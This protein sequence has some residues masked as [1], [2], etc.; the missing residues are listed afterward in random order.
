MNPSDVYKNKKA[1]GWTRIEMLLALYEAGIRNIHEAQDARLIKNHNLFDQ[2]RLHALRI[3]LEIRGGLNS[4]Y[5]ELPEK[6]AVLCEYVG[7]CLLDGSDEKMVSAVNVLTTLKESFDAIREEANRLEK[8][9]EI[10]S[11]VDAASYMSI[12]A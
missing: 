2:K 4:E 8:A 9:G 5:G 11:V 12:R 1:V 6:I 7:Q 10:P 3:V